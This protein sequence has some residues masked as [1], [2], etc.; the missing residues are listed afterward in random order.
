MEKDLRISSEKSFGIVFSA[1]F[2]IIA[3][4]LYINDLDYYFLFLLG[5]IFFLITGFF[6]PRI[7][8]YPN[9]IWFKFG[10]LLSKV[11][12][13]IIMLFLYFVVICPMGI[14]YKFFKKKQYTDK[15]DNNLKSYWIDRKEDL[16]SMDRQF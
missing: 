12:T 6:L 2:F 10:L 15:F 11:T 9:I 16:Q 4:Y 14:I 1:V 3:G 13:P 8:K 7:L 5:S